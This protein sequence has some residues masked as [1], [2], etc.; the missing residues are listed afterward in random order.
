MS[1]VVYFVHIKHGEKTNIDYL[2]K[3]HRTSEIF[4]SEL[5]RI[6]TAYFRKQILS[7]TVA[8]RLDKLQ[9]FFCMKH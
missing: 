4:R 1:A 9:I 7:E 2:R 5:M 6:C 8:Y 3:K